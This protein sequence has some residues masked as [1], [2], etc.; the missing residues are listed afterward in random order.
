MLSNID[1]HRVKVAEEQRES[2]Q[3]EGNVCEEEG[4]ADQ[5][6]HG[7]PHVPLIKPERGHQQ[8]KEAD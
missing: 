5:Q 1:P 3:T 2:E 7:A 8:V 4:K 6:S